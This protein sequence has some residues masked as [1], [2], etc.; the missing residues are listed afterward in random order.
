MDTI[1]KNVRYSYLHNYN[2]EKISIFLV[3]FDIQKNTIMKKILV[4]LALLVSAVT[5]GQDLKS[6]TKSSVSSSK[7]L[8]N[9]YIDKIAS[10]QVGKLTK[11]LNLSEGQQRQTNELIMQQLRSDKF[12]KML[13]KY[14]PDQLMSSE[15]SDTI[16][17]A[18][19]SEQ[20]FNTD[21]S[22]ILDEDQQDI[23]SKILKEK[24]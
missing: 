17:K 2:N 20:N 5:L 11:K 9:D 10:D 15:G 18:I 13:S 23:L 1:Y 24:G 12:Q 6:M 8:D 4:M 3:T 14:T 21:L 22:G 7:L 19:M 16:T